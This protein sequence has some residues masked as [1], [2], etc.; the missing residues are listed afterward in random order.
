VDIVSALIL[1]SSSSQTITLNIIQTGEEKAEKKIQG[2]KRRK[3]I[4]Q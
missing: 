2:R 3:K 4:K 1:L